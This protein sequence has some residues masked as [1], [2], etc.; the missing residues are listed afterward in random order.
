[1]KR[2]EYLGRPSSTGALVTEDAVVSGLMKLQTFARLPATGRIDA[3][4]LKVFQLRHGQNFE[5]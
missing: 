4:T 5:L 3:A 1:M 2:Y